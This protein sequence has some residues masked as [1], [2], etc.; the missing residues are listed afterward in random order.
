MGDFLPVCLLASR[1]RWSVLDAR[2]WPFAVRQLFT[3]TQGMLPFIEAAVQWIK[4]RAPALASD[5]CV[6]AQLLARMFDAPRLAAC[7]GTPPAPPQSA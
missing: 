6:D 4:E 3:E 7:L 2:Y 5:Q 1:Q